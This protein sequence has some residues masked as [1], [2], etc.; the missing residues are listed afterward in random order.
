MKI[1]QVLLTRPGSWEALAA[2]PGDAQVLLVFGAVSFFHEAGLVP[3]LTQRC[4]GAILVG[5]S[6]SGEVTDQGVEEGCCTVTALSF[7][8]VRLQAFATSLADMGDSES[9]GVRLGGDLLAPDLNAVL[10]FGPGVHING[11]ALLQGLSHTLG[12][13]IPVM[14]GLAGDGGAFVQTYTLSPGGISDHQVV[15][16]GLYGEG[17]VLGHGSLGGWEPFGPER[18]VTRSAGNVLYELDGEPALDIYKRYLGAHAAGLPASGLLF[19]FAMGGEQEGKDGL[20]RTI[21]GVDEHS[22]SLILAGD[23]HEGGSL[24]LMH[25]STDRLVDGAEGAAM[26]AMEMLQGGS[27]ALALLVSCIGRKLVMGDRVDEEVEAV[28]AVFGQGAVLTG[29]YSNG[30]ISPF[31]PG[32]ACRLHNQ[33]MTVTT[34]MEKPA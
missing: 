19:P 3:A 18:R 33:T 31:M 24:K 11:S 27:P 6:S 29:F 5:C 17:L 20:I 16:L 21:L 8:R 25:A 14:G 26:A 2:L 15:A 30:E 13:N 12:A 28:A 7:E 1:D 23:V 22:G 4:P 34:L 10:L 9:A 32:G